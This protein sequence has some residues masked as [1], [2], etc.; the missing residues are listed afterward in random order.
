MTSLSEQ[1][2][3]F[4]EKVT[5]LSEQVT[6]IRAAMKEDADDATHLLDRQALGT[7]LTMLLPLQLF[8]LTQLIAPRPLSSLLS[9]SQLKG[10]LTGVLQSVLGSVVK[11]LVEGKALSLET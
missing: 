10:V 9:S 6:S 8:L 7:I 2:T 4:S 3:S 1:V 5:L 11:T